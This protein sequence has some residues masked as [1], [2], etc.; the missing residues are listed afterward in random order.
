VLRHVTAREKAAMDRRMQRFDASVEHLREAR[1]GLHVAHREVRRSKYARRS[2]RG[3]EGPA[4]RVEFGGEVDDASLVEN[5]EKCGG[6]QKRVK[7]Q[8]SGVT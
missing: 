6:H 7:G 1:Q 3:Y 4:K 8:G 2:A 5:G